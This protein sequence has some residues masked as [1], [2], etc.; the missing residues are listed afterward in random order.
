MRVVSVLGATAILLTFGGVA[1]KAD[2]PNVPRWS[3]YAIMGYDQSTSVN[4]Q[5]TSP[6]TSQDTMQEGRAADVATSP[7]GPGGPPNYARVRHHRTRPYQ[8]NMQ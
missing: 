3:P 6:S 8:D 5:S 7:D 1:A 2:N 4:S